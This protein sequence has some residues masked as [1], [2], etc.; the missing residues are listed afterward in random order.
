MFLVFV[1]TLNKDI[2]SY[3]ILPDTH[4]WKIPLFCCQKQQHKTLIHTVSSWVHWQ[5]WKRHWGI[6]DQKYNVTEQTNKTRHSTIAMRQNMISDY[7]SLDLF[8][9]A[10]HANIPTYIENLLMLW[11]LPFN[12]QQMS[13]SKKEFHPNSTA[14]RMHFQHLILTLD[15]RG[16][17]SQLTRSICQH[18]GCWCPGSLCHYVISTHDTDYVKEALHVFI[19]WYE[20]VYISLIICHF[21]L[22]WFILFFLLIYVVQ[23]L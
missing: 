4:M 23:C 14:V 9:V 7:F 5:T 12:I 2:L 19:S 8:L 16:E 13:V 20:C 17:S 10:N 15:A 18:H 22:N 11:R 6:A 3:L 1:S 21:K